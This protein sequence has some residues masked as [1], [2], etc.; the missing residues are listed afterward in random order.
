M[1][2][3]SLSSLHGSGKA[4][5]NARTRSKDN[6]KVCRSKFLHIIGTLDPDAQTAR[7]MP[8]EI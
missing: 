1:F 8:V 2:P 3:A 6:G 7:P 5:G 4:G